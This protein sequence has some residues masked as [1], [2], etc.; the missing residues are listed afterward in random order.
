MN[1]IF[2]TGIPLHDIL[3]DVELQKIFKNGDLSKRGVN[4]DDV[5]RTFDGFRDA[6]RAAAPHIRIL[7]R[8]FSKIIDL[9]EELNKLDLTGD[10][11]DLLGCKWW[12]RCE[13]GKL[14]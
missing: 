12:C 11:T 6:A 9:E 5:P 14:M 2:E 1:T 3:A 8:N 7:A 4:R 13:E 10:G